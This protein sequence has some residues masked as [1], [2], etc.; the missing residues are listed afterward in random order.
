MKNVMTVASDGWGVSSTLGALPGGK[1]ILHVSK[2]RKLKDGRVVFQ[3]GELGEKVF[4]STQEAH[5]AAFQRGYS[6]RS[7]NRPNL[8]ISLRL[9]PATRKFL[10][11][12]SPAEAKLY[13]IR[14]GEASHISKGYVGSI[15]S[16]PKSLTAMRWMDYLSNPSDWQRFAGK[17]K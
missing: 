11:T 8:F 12:K 5:E 9:S 3:N 10:A 16:N 1:V 7:F 6:A 15:L 4:N 14:L 13:L 2:M 17:F